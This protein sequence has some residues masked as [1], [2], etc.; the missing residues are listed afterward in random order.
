MTALQQ[1]LVNDLNRN[2]EKIAA[3]M[4]F[5]LVTKGPRLE[6]ELRQGEPIWRWQTALEILLGQGLVKFDRRTDG[7]WWSARQIAAA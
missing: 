5:D 3:R 4:Y 6:N 7:L 2:A 1:T